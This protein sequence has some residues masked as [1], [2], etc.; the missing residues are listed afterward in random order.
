MLQTMKSPKPNTGFPYT[1]AKI[2][3]CYSI[4]HFGY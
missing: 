3:I 2:A 1:L 4:L